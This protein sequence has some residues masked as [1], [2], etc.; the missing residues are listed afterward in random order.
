MGKKIKERK[1]MKIA[2]TSRD[3]RKKQYKNT[4]KAKQEKKEGVKF[5]NRGI[6]SKEREGKAAAALDKTVQIF[7]TISTSSGPWAEKDKTAAFDI[8]AKLRIARAHAAGTLSGLSDEQMEN[9]CYTQL[10]NA[11]KMAAGD[12]TNANLVAAKTQVLKTE[13]CAEDYKHKM[14][15]MNIAKLKKARILKAKMKKKA[16]N[17]KSNADEQAS[18]KRQEK[19]GKVDE[20]RDVLNNKI[21]L[22]SEKAQKTTNTEKRHKW[23]AKEDAITHDMAVAA[24][25]NGDGLLKRKMALLKI[26][27]KKTA[28]AMKK[29]DELK[30]E[31]A[32]ASEK[33]E[34]GVK[35]Y[36]SAQAALKILKQN[37]GTDVQAAKAKAKSLAETV[38]KTEDIVKE[39]NIKAATADTQARRC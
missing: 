7:K 6:T 27:N 12:P 16:M 28:L 5:Q 33:R 4:L 32:T 8:L 30:K 29:C 23:Q 14:I 26:R 19:K 17:K 22:R 2:K 36:A 24:A 38:K 25:K 20:T 18:K 31:K 3:Q 1:K 10:H 13:H 11:L 15:K 21:N 9:P 34:K 39:R 37:P 35:N